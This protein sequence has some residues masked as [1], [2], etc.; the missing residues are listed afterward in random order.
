MRGDGRNGAMTES[1]SLGRSASTLSRIF[2][3]GSTPRARIGLTSSV[4]NLRAI[5]TFLPTVQTEASK[6]DERRGPKRRNHAEP[7][8]GV[9]DPPARQ[10][11][12][13]SRFGRDLFEGKERFDSERVERVQHQKRNPEIGKFLNEFPACGEERDE[14]DAEKQKQPRAYAGD[15][16]LGAIVCEETPRPVRA[17]ETRPRAIKSAR[18]ASRFFVHRSRP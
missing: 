15:E 6:R 11:C 4:L 9:G 17:Q 3:N 18:K 12:F 8:S 13:V 16:C 2:E 14:I 1:P 5:V 10:R 7:K